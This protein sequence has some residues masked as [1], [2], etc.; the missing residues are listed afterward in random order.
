MVGFFFDLGQPTLDIPFPPSSVYQYGMQAGSKI[1]SSSFGIGYNDYR[2]GEYNLDSFMFDNP[3][4]LIIFA[5][6]N[7]GDA[8]NAVGAPA[9]CK[10]GLSGR[11][12]SS[13][14]LC[15]CHK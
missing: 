11:F 7:S 9:T 3:D 5:A 1:H 14:R 12:D 15:A 2:G 4:L 8:V 10:N 13:A 6:G